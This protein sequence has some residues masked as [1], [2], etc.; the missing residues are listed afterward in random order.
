MKYGIVQLGKKQVKIRLCFCRLP[1]LPRNC[2]PSNYTCQ[3]NLLPSRWLRSKIT[4]FCCSSQHNF[5]LYWLEAFCVASGFISMVPSYSVLLSSLPIARM[6]LVKVLSVL[7]SLMTKESN[8]EDNS[9][10]VPSY[11][12]R[13]Q[14]HCV[15]SKDCHMGWQ[16][17]KAIKIIFEMVARN[18]NGQQHYSGMKVVVHCCFCVSSL[19]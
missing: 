13:S 15:N 8:H 16:R 6:S 10:S 18:I 14:W 5:L 17:E 1:K 7:E 19:M 2:T 3:M 9:K 12:G 11:G 4:T